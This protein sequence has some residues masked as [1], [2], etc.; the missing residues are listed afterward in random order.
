MKALVF[1]ERRIKRTDFNKDIEEYSKKVLQAKRVCNSSKAT[2]IQQDYLR[3]LTKDL[4][5]TLRGDL[6]RAMKSME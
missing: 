5:D 6:M 2:M 1:G 3:D 4:D